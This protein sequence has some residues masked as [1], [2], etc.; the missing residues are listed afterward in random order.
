MLING[1]TPD[2]VPCNPEVC[3]VCSGMT[4]GAHFVQNFVSLTD[5][6]LKESMSLADSLYNLQLVLD[7][8]REHLNR[9]CHFSLEDMLYASSS[10]K[11]SHHFT[12][13]YYKLLNS[14]SEAA[15]VMFIL[16]RSHRLRL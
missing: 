12:Q 10:I 9:C 3:C 7:F 11:V 13:L 8:C 16:F 2:W 6:C 5:V 1:L 14:T 4:S 15:I